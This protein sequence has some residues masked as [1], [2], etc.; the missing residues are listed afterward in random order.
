MGCF[1]P[2][3]RAVPYYL[4]G[5]GGRLADRP[6]C[7]CNRAI[8]RNS[9]SGLRSH[10]ETEPSGEHCLTLVSEELAY[11]TLGWHAEIIDDMLTWGAEPMIG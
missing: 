5:Q 7:N 4:M 10:R 3:V 1:P 8:L 11:D 2:R 6:R 9:E